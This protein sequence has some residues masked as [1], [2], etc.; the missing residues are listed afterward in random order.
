MSEQN[1]NIKNELGKVL[2]NKKLVEP[3]LLSRAFKSLNGNG[4]TSKSLANILVNDFKFD[5]HTIFTE[6]SE[7]YAFKLLEYDEKDESHKSINTIKGL[8][9]NYEPDFRKNL[10]NLKVLPFA[11]DDEI[12][13]KIIFGAVD[14]TNTEISKLIN[15]LNLSKYEIAYLPPHSFNH[16]IEVIDPK[17]NEFL[18]NFEQ[19]EEEE[20]TID[21]DQTLDE[22]LIE[23][24]INK[25]ALINLFEGALIEGVR[26]GVSDI[27]FSPDSKKSI[28]I[29]FRVDGKLKEWHKQEKT[30]PEAMIAVIK[31]R[32]RGLNRFEREEAQ[33][34]FIQREIDGQVIRFRVS[35]LPIVG[36]EFRNKFERVVIRILD[37]R[38]VITDL[39][40]LG[41]VGYARKIF[42]DAI[43]KPQGMVILTGPT[44]CG[45]S[46]TLVA[47][48][49][50][51]INPSIN[52]LTVEDPV[53]YVIK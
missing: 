22:N 43:H 50:Q 13:N 31:D 34:G 29:H 49:H 16:I 2:L 45:K 38:N 20:Y 52:V 39:D 26:K 24:E 14:P 3:Q 37:D 32:S 30:M 18:R 17:E 23:V 51:V 5:H 1:I 36:S 4:Q 11:F 6:L 48:L 41:L 33:D 40:K 15:K 47:A 10:L 12:K 25:S 44:G 9:Q 28:S 8:M 53:E 21:D 7:L 46:T 27:H 19:T 42:E 35:I